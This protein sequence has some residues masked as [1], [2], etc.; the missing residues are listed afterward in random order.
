VPQYNLLWLC[1]A[2]KCVLLWEDLF[3]FCCLVFLFLVFVG[4]I[5]HNRSKGL[6]TDL[7]LSLTRKGL[8]P[9]CLCYRN[10]KAGGK[11]IP[12]IFGINDLIKILELNL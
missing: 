3:Q 9:W 12:S 1:L 2:E 7:R 5:F 8:G 6:P 4:W 10:P 11:K